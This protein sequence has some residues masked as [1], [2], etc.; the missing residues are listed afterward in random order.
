VL[1]QRAALLSALHGRSEA[2]FIQYATPCSPLRPVASSARLKLSVASSERAATLRIASRMSAP[3][4]CRLISSRRWSKVSGSRQL[5]S[6]RMA[7]KTS[8]V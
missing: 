7:T 3:A 8:D 5:R 1:Q 4:G 2:V 6:A